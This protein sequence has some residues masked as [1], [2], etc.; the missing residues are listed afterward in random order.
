MNNISQRYYGDKAVPNMDRT[1]R[2]CIAPVDLSSV[3]IDGEGWAVDETLYPES[4]G[5]ICHQFDTLREAVLFIWNVRCEFKSEPIDH[6]GAEF[7]DFLREQAYNALSDM[8]DAEDVSICS[9]A[10]ARI[11]NI[12]ELLV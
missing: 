7:K 11:E 8:L 6:T 4:R 3:Y 10:G 9:E 5:Y 1:E 12:L 2:R